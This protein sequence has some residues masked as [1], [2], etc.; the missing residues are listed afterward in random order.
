VSRGSEED[1][2]GHRSGQGPQ[3]EQQARP[4]RADRADPDVEREQCVQAAEQDGGRARALDG[5]QIGG[6]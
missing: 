2:G 4:V 5:P 1:D 6:P 3:R